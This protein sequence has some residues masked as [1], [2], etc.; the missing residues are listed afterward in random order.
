MRKYQLGWPAHSTSSSS[1]RSKGSVTALALQFVDDAAV[2]DAPHLDL[3][4]VFAVEEPIAALD[5]RQNV[6]DGDAEFALRDQE[7]RQRLLVLGIDLHQD[8]VLRIVIGDDEPPHQL[9]VGIA[10]TVR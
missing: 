5:Q 6:D 8:H 3:A 10:V 9:P 7:I 2:V 1:R 4:A